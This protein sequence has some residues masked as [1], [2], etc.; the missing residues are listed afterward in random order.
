MRFWWVNHKQTYRQEI[1]GG[2][3]WSPKAKINGV[4]NQSYDY[5]RLV[6]PAPDGRTPLIG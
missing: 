3:I 5:M 2:Y 4:R 1:G 6:E